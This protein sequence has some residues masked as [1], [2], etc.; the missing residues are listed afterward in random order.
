MKEALQFKNY[1]IFTPEQALG[2]PKQKLMDVAGQAAALINELGGEHM[3]HPPAEVLFS[4][5]QAGMACY[6]VDG[7]GNLGGFIKVDPWLNCPGGFGPMPDGIAGKLTAIESG[8]AALGI[9]ETGSLVVHPKDQGNGLGT[10]L[11]VQMSKQASVHFPGVPVIAV[12]TNDNGP[13]IH[14]NQ[15][16]GWI[17]VENDTLKGATGI[18]VLDGWVPE[19]T[20]F[21][22]P[23]SAHAL[24]K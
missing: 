12:V 10:Q 11:K 15:K 17:P 4:Y 1:Q 22:S 23:E 5:L 16:L 2:M 20:I 13:S 18:D 9:L 21:V 8:N 3:F 7:T 24:Y 14:N 6:A 19:S